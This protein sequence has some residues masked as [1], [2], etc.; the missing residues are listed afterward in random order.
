MEQEK[1][2]EKMASADLDEVVDSVT[3]FGKVFSDMAEGTLAPAKLLPTYAQLVEQSKPPLSP[4][5]QELALDYADEPRELGRPAEAAIPDAQGRRP[6]PPR[7]RRGDRPGP[8]RARLQRRPADHPPADPD[9]IP[10]RRDRH[11]L[12]SHLGASRRGH[13]RAGLVAGVPDPRRASFGRRAHRHLRARMCNWR[14]RPSSWTPQLDA[15]P[16][17]G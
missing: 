8:Q 12:E 13:R 15:R 10:P 17:V 16:S 3:A 5:A 7:T 1:V 11:R 9:P 6:L 4:D 14:F 2:Y